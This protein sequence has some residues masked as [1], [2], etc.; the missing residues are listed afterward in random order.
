[1][2]ICG[3]TLVNIGT[4]SQR[5]IEAMVKAAKKADAIGKCWVLDPVGAGA[6]PLRLNT[7]KELL[8]YHPTVIRGNASEIFALAGLAN[9]SRGVDSTDSSSAAINAGKALAKEYHCVVGITG[10]VDYV[11]DGERVIESESV[12]MIVTCSSQRSADVHADHSSWLL[13]HLHN[14][15]LPC[16]WHC[17][18]GSYR[19]R[20]Y[21][22]GMGDD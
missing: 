22:N 4:L 20:N 17:T 14:L 1:M 19:F 15:C 13:S 9:G 8:K 6:T 3:S 16:Y 2:S 18:D 5:W 11:T 12:F 10:E 21:F 7:C